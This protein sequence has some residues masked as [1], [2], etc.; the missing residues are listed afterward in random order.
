M[1]EREIVEIPAKIV[2]NA[3]T[4]KRQLRVA[5]YCRVSTSQEAQQNSFK[6]Q[7]E[8]YT[9]KIAA[10]P[11]WTLVGIFADEGITGTSAD[12]RPGFQKMIR[13][14]QKGKIDYIITKSVS[15]FSRNTLECL[16][17]VR[18]LQDL[19][20]PI[21]FESEGLNNFYAISRLKYHRN[22]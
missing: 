17:Y 1:S 9:E 8:Y 7:R 14:C 15:R 3:E 18:L 10:N 4:P 6:R 19:G 16:Y 21:L 20:V 22:R 12:K 13:W 5:A 11:D 2:N